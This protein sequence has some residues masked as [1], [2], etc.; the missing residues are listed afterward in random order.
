MVMVVNDEMSTCNHEDIKLVGFD[1]AVLEYIYV[2]EI[3]R[4]EWGC[5]SS[6][7]LSKLYILYLLPYL[8]KYLANPFDLSMF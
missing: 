8:T 2:L 1:G 7:I 4:L 3:E 6:T 5:L